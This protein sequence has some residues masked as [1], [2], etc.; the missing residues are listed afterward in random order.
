MDLKHLRYFI[1]VAE[2]GSFHRAARRLCIAQPAL[3]RR[4]RDLEDELEVALFERSSRGVRLTAAGEVLCTEARQIM[5]QLETARERTRLAAQGRYGTVNVG[6]TTVVAQMRAAVAAIGA[7]KRSVAGVNFKLHLVP[8]DQQMGALARGEIDLGL[9]YRRPPYPPGIAYR[10]LRRDRYVVM[11]ARDH[12]LAGRGS[13]RLADLSGEDMLF[14]SPTL[15][16]ETYREMLAACQRGGL[17]P[18]IALEAEGLV[19]MVA[20]GLAVSLYNSALAASAAI[21]GVTYLE[22]E[23]LDI[24]LQLAVA[25]EKSRETPAVLALVALLERGF[26][27]DRTDNH[28]TR[29]PN[30]AG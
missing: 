29:E 27:G 24:P 16:P 26:A 18:R 13:I 20:E 7:A 4:V 3:S 25:W 14:P 15:R 28:T 2:E 12:R 22:V 10:D 19:S 5:A 9:Q 6:L 30:N 1:A 17:E 23:D 21:D 8:S 11:V